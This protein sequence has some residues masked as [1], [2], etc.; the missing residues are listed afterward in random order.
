MIAGE[1][2]EITLRVHRGVF[3]RGRV[4]DP[5]GEPQPTA[6]VWAWSGERSGLQADC[7]EGGSFSLG[8][9]VPGRYTLI[10]LRSGN[11]AP[12]D[13]VE[14]DA[15]QE[16]VE[17]RLRPGGS[18]R[19]RVVDARTGQGCQAE[20]RLALEDGRKGWDEHGIGWSSHEDG[21]FDADGL[22]PGLYDLSAG[23]KDG[24]FGVLRSVGVSAG[25]ETSDLVV[26]VAPGG[27]LRLRYEGSRPK[28]TCSV[29]FQGVPIGWAQ[30]LQ[31][32]DATV[33]LAPAGTLL[34]GL[35]AENGQEIST[36]TVELGA[37]EESEVL[38]RDGE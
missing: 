33:R 38:F 37:G 21:S 4:V 19:G 11:L 2:Q 14:A 36:R 13:P 29:R 12:S 30:D 7:G 8:P 20:M 23:T 26:A 5:A 25:A 27:K 3:I 9:L 24:R 35:S 1:T 16:S 6:F 31:A 18:L 10:A 15:G 32:G 28:V 22:A 34:L 17:L